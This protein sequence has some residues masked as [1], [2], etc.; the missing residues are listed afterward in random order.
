M[1]KIDNETLTKINLNNEES[2]YFKQKSIFNYLFKTFERM[3]RN[4]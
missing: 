3:W 1:L 2:I 4:W